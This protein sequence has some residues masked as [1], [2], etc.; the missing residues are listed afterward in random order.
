MYAASNTM[1]KGSSRWMLSCQRMAYGLRMFGLKMV[2][3]CP[4]LV[5]VPLA[6]PTGWRKPLGNGSESE[7]AGDRELLLV[8]L[9]TVCWLKPGWLGAGSWIGS[10]RMP[11]PPRITVLLPSARGVQAKPKRG[12]KILL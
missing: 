7:A 1:W 4:R 9:I 11:K 5:L 2:M 3:L 6:A 8:T 12:L 10:T